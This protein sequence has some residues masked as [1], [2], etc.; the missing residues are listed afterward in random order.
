MFGWAT[1]HL[2][3]SSMVKNGLKPEK[4][5]EMCAKAFIRSAFDH[6]RGWQA[7][8]MENYPSEDGIYQLKCHIMTL[9]VIMG[10]QSLTAAAASYLIHVHTLPVCRYCD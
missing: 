5:W 3:Y 7:C 8:Q 2:T 6:C 1:A 10:H 4:G 9:G